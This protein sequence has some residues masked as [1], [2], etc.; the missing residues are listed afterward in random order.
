MFVIL[1]MLYIIIG[2]AEFLMN[3]KISCNTCKLTCIFQVKKKNVQNISVIYIIFFQALADVKENFCVADKTSKHLARSV[4]VILF[5][6]C[7]ILC[8]ERR[9]TVRRKSQH[10]AISSIRRW[11]VL[12]TYFISGIVLRSLKLKKSATFSTDIKMLSASY[13]LFFIVFF[14]Y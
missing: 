7:P 3:L 6:A 13:L 8:K 9:D 5:V 12:R 4:P 11:Q 1:V 2:L 10:M 14:I